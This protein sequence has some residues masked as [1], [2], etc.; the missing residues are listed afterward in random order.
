MSFRVDYGNFVVRRLDL[1]FHDADTRPLGRAGFIIIYNWNCAQ[2][3]PFFSLQMLSRY[4][5]IATASGAAV[6]WHSI[7][8]E[9][10]YMSWKLACCTTIDPISHTVISPQ[11]GPFIC[12]KGF[13]PRCGPPKRCPCCGAQG[14]VSMRSLYL[15]SLSLIPKMAENKCW[16]VVEPIPHKKSHCHWA[17]SQEVWEII[18]VGNS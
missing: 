13:V 18:V 4:K 15:L 3:E 5:E 12:P 16:F 11:C 17:S 10:R 14:T 6:A 1:K 8:E 2:V 7:P 9:E